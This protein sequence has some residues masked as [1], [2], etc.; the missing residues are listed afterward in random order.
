MAAFCFVNDFL[1]LLVMT[2]II[3][4]TM[5]RHDDVVEAFSFSV[6]TTT[7]TTTVGRM[8]G[9]SSSRSL[10]WSSSLSSSLLSRSNSNIQLK[11]QISLFSY[12]DSLG[13]QDPQSQQVTSSPSTYVPSTAATTTTTISSSN[14]YQNDEGFQSIPQLSLDHADT[15]ASNVVAVCKRNGFNPVTV[16]VLDA[17][18]STI[19]SKRMDGCSPVGIPDFAKA[20]AYSCVVNRYS[21]RTFRDRYTT[22]EV[23]AKFCQLLGMVAITGGDMAPFPGGILLKVGDHVVGAV[24]VSGAAGDEDEYCAIRSV[25]ESNIGGLTTVPE[26]HSCSTVQD[27]F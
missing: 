27:R 21:S 24:G 3:I 19:V 10:V 20:K 12:L 14:P 7:T 2:T 23:S 26:Q 6:G 15:I 18:G 4:N 13:S 9:T 1:V 17:W 11:Q 22:E 8:I 16:Y 5:H 25:V